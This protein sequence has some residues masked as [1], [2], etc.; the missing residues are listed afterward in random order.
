MSEGHFPITAP[1]PDRWIQVKSKG[2]PKPFVDD[3]RQH[4][5]QATAPQAPDALRIL[6][7]RLARG[8]IDVDDYATRRNALVSGGYG[9]FRP[10]PTAP[11]DPPRPPAE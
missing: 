9:S 8:D 2:G 10:E 1:L 7:E 11:S 3:L 4:A 6:D 5:H